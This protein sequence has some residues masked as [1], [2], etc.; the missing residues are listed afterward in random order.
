MLICLVMFIFLLP[1]Q[2]FYLL[3]ENIVGISLN[4]YLCFITL[5]IISNI[6]IKWSHVKIPEFQNEDGSPNYD[7]LIDDAKTYKRF[8]MDNIIYEGMSNI[9]GA[10]Y[11]N[12]LK[13]ENKLLARQRQ[14]LEPLNEKVTQRQG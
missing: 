7:A 13:Y 5:T 3:F 2:L 8:L 10:Q 12:I 6:P 1:F 4:A 9:Y 14:A 11:N